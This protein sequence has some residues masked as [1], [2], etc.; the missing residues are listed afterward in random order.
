MSLSR[1]LSGWRLTLRRAAAVLVVGLTLGWASNAYADLF[2][3]GAFN[4]ARIL[5]YDEATGAF[6]GNLSDP[7]SGL[8]FPTAVR[9]GADG[10]LYVANDA[11]STGNVLRFDVGTGGFVGVFADVGTMG[12]PPGLAFGP[13][14]NLYVAVGSGSGDSVLRFSGITGQL[15]DT[16]VPFI[17][18]VSNVAHYMIF[19]PDGNLYLTGGQGGV[20]RYDGTTGALIDTFIPFLSGGLNNAQGLAFGPDGNLYVASLLSDDVLRYNGQ[21]GA[22]IDVFI[23]DVGNAAFGLSDIFFGPDNLLYVADTGGVGTSGI[24]RFDANTGQFVDV[25]VAEGSGGLEVPISMA[26]TPETPVS[27]SSLLLTLIEE[28]TD[29]NLQQGTQ[30][31]LLEK[32]NVAST[33]LEDANQSNDIAAIGALRAFIHYLSARKAVVDSAGN[34]IPPEQVAALMEAAEEIIELL[35]RG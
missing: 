27:P 31:S 25:F 24:L 22:F 19:G 12:R 10:Y 23:A 7:L 17:G 11:V 16:F 33:R 6:V 8:I 18:G 21:T 3:A 13:D 28:V 5:R 20:M 35:E 1:T 34:P 30:S 9:F 14:G 4:T 2:V 32:L 26:M 29:L 15:I